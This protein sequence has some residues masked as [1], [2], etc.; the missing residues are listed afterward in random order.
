MNYNVPFH[1][2]AGGWGSGGKLLALKFYG[3]ALLF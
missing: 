1:Q 3:G 2:G